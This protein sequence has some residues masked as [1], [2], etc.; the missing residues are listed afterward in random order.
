MSLNE[1][2]S[3]ACK[4]AFFGLYNIKQIWKYLSI[5]A[6]KILVHALVTCHL[7][8]CNSFLFVSLHYQIQ[9]LQRVLN[10]ATRVV[11]LVPEYSHITPA[12]KDLHWLPVKYRIMFKIL[13]LVCKVQLGMAPVYLVSLFSRKFM[14]AA[15]R[16]QDNLLQ[17]PITKY[18]TFEDRAFFKAGPTL[19]NNLSSTNH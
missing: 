2:I 6:T 5:D 7:D 17:I 18:K 3:K 10:A 12:L 13:L 11:C 8:Y 1:H 14:L 15:I 16:N 4:K 19:W 9:R